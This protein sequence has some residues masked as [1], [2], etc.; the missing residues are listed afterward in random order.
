V[1]SGANDS[2]FIE[3]VAA[4]TGAAILARVR[5]SVVSF[6][7]GAEEEVVAASYG[8]HSGEF[9]AGVLE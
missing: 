8:H 5:D 4:D 9:H 7:I 3:V 2:G 6:V 1:R